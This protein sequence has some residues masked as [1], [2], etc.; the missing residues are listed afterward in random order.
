MNINSSCFFY[1]I[2][3]SMLTIVRMGYFFMH[4]GTGRVCII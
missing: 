4:K 1:N 3:R 2:K